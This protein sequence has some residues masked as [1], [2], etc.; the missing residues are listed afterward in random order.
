MPLPKHIAI[1]PDGNRRWAKKRN[2]PA[3]EG[4]RAGF[5]QAKKLIQKAWSMGIVALTLWAFSTDNWKREIDEVSYLMRLYERM[6]D[7]YLQEAMKRKSRI[8]HLGRKDRINKTLCKKIINAEEKTAH[9]TGH[10][11]CIA[12]DYGGRDEMMRA[13]NE[14]QSQKLKVKSINEAMLHQ[15]L[16]TRNVPYPDV[17]LVIRT[18]GEKRTSGLMIWQAAYAEYYFSDAYFP[19]FSPRDLED[20]IE[21]YQR[22]HRRFGK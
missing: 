12:L 14:V 9:F 4:H 10:T 13:I 22:R 15:L 17:D 8:I 18:S 6:I 16:D 2:L 1:I 11:L 5:T 7:E 3:W 21:E 20:A 19:D